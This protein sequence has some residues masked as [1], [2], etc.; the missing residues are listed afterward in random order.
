MVNQASE[1]VH[2]KINARVGDNCKFQITIAAA[3]QLIHVVS[4]YQDPWLFKAAKVLQ[5]C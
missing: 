4:M 3:V 1:W 2:R 5:N